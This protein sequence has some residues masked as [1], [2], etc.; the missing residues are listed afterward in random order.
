MYCSTVGRVI[1]QGQVQCEEVSV[2]RFCFGSALSALTQTA[3]LLSA[4][5]TKNENSQTLIVVSIVSEY[6]LN[7]RQQF[8]MQ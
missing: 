3:I 7:K 5:W 6:R 8:K 2:C 4:L 1:I